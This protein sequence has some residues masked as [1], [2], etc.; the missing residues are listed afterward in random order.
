[1]PA[2]NY[3]R[4]GIISD[5]HGDAAVCEHIW[6]TYFKK[7]DLIL[8]AGDVLY[9]GPRNPLP[10]GY[11]PQA[12]AGLLNASP[13]P[14]LFARGNC[15]A[16]VDQLVLDY[17]LQTPYLIIQLE[18]LRIMVHHGTDLDKCQMLKMAQ[19]FKLD[20]FIS[21]HT[22]ERTLVKDG[23]VILLNPGSP[24]LPKGDGIPSVALIEDGSIKIID[25]RQGTIL[26]TESLNRK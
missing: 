5:T 16:D 26:L 20:L 14:V 22:H 6:K 19:Q 9:H 1:M 8:H 24:S 2:Y 23:Q 3:A 10:E 13:A 12:L 25:V 21:G 4:L 15:D 18:N 7:V 17:P 11:N